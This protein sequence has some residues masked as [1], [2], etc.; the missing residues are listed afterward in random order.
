MCRS[1][2]PSCFQWICLFSLVLS[3]CGGGDVG[4]K[5]VRVSGVVTLHGK[6]LEGAEVRF[7]GSNFT[8][9]GKTNAEGKYELVQGAVPGNNKIIISKIEGGAG[10]TLDPEAGMDAEQLRTAA[11][12]VQADPTAR[13]A[14]VA[15]IPKE[16]VPAEYSDPMKTKLS[17]PVPESGSSSADFRL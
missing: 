14:D 9:F 4:P 2:P 12:S 10:I 7:I 16:V 8:G 11:A 6:A 1:T 13:K 3:G 5:T 17:F 15:K